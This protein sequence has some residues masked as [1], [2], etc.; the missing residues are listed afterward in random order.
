MNDRNTERVRTER[1]AFQARQFVTAAQRC[2]GFHING[3]DMKDW[4]PNAQVVNYALGAE[5]ALKGLQLLHMGKAERGH[6]LSKLCLSLPLAVQEFVRKDM[7]KALFDERLHSLRLAFEEWRYAHESD[8]DISISI[9][10][11]E[12][13]A[14]SSTKVLE[15]ALC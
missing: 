14:T 10:F 9:G 1:I 8:V 11:L 15:V 4:L 13:L 7:P 2:G 5:L 12:H 6:D 3:F